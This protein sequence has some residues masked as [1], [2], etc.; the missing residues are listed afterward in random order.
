MKQTYL[1]N[2]LHMHGSNRVSRKFLYKTGALKMWA[3]HTGAEA[4]LVNTVTR[5]SFGISF[6]TIAGDRP[7]AHILEHSVLCNAAGILN[8]DPLPVSQ[9]SLNTFFE[10]LRS[11]PTS[12]R[13]IWIASQNL[14]CGISI[15]WSRP[16]WTPGS[17]SEAGP[18][19]SG[20]AG[21]ALRVGTHPRTPP[22]WLR[23]LSSM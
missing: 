13:Q 8:S 7:V 6:R 18:V 15:I 14:L 16:T 2:G 23:A 12:T 22:S 19:P 4:S 5:I 11:I 9:G 3:H 21:L 20:G 17:L 1:R 10:C